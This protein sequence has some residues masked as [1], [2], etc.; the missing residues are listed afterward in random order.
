MHNL[1]DTV[2]PEFHA[3]STII[4]ELPCLTNPLSTTCTLCHAYL[5]L[6]VSFLNGVANNLTV[7]VIFRR[8]PLQRSIEAPDICDMHGDGRTRLFWWDC[9]K[10]QSRDTGGGFCVKL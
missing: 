1:K 3:S 6:L 10:W 9:E 2:A 4:S 7:A 8:L 5:S